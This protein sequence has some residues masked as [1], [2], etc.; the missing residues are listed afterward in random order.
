M[1]APDIKEPKI[2]LGLTTYWLDL[3]SLVKCDD[4]IKLQEKRKANQRPEL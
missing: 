2:M 1:H 4:L 3:A